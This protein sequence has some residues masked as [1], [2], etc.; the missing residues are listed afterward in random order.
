MAV[1]IRLQRKGARHMAFYRIVVADSRAPRDGRFVEQLGYYDP[2]KDPAVI[3]VDAEKAIGWLGN[4][5]Q[6]SE[7]VRSLFSRVGIMETWHEMKKG[8]PFDE[9]RHIEEEARKKIE[10][11]AAMERRKK[12]EKKGKKK[13][14]AEKETT[15]VAAATPESDAPAA[16]APVE[17]AAVA[18]VE[19]DASNESG[20]AAIEPA[21]GEDAAE[22][23]A[24]D[25]A[26]EPE[27]VAE[28]AADEQGSA[29]GDETK[30]E[31]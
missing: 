8:R 9:L 30:T 28:P 25:A 26:P 3:S 24:D 13:A 10:V 7:T 27:P 1:R 23:P 4:G 6:P 31:G 29:E 11:R 12:E 20:E 15:E 17:A 22:A 16:E 5:A 19:A 14:E 21:K 2:L 18:E